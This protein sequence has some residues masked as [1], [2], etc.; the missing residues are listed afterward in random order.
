MSKI[1]GILKVLD[2]F[3][4][5]E[6]HKAKDVANKLDVNVSTIWWYINQIEDANIEYE[7][8]RITGPNGGYRMIKTNKLKIEL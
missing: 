3:S 8:E 5:G 2:I 6:I 1:N 4:D 7:F